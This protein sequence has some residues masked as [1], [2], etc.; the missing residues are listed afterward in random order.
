MAYQQ[1]EGTSL[2][3]Y[4][5]SP[6]GSACSS[7]GSETSLSPTPS[8]QALY[9]PAGR[10]RVTLSYQNHCQSYMKRLYTNSR[11]RWRQQHVNLA[12]GELRK[13]LPTYPP[14]R[15]L[16]KNEILR[17]AMKYIGFLDNLL[18]DMDDKTE[19]QSQDPRK[20]V[21]DSNL[22]EERHEIEKLTCEGHT[23]FSLPSMDE[24]HINKPESVNSGSIFDSP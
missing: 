7:S 4:T 2:E 15:K 8:P 22:K 14:E 10:R 18:Q 6:V 19:S 3:S 24:M 13:L 16:S 9:Y 21:S 23:N 11:E 5:H 17:L 20:D 12:F 1:F